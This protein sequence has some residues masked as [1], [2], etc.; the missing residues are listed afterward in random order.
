MLYE[1]G[2]APK[3]EQLRDANVTGLGEGDV[4]VRTNNE[5]KSNGKVAKRTD[6]EDAVGWTGKNY[7]KIIK[8]SGTNATV[9]FTR[10]A[11]NS[12]TVNGTPNADYATYQIIDR[13]T[14][15]LVIPA[16][17]YIVTGCPEG[18]S[19]ETYFMIVQCTRSGALYT[20]GN[21]AGDGLEITVLDGDVMQLTLAIMAGTTASNMVFY[22][23][24]RRAD[25][26]DSTYEPYHDS[27]DVCK[28]DEDEVSAIC[29]VYGSKNLLKFEPLL[30]NGTITG[31]VQANGTLRYNGTTSGIAWFGISQPTGNPVG[32]TY[33]TLLRKGTYK[34][35]VKSSQALS[36]NVQV[37]LFSPAATTIKN[38]SSGTNNK[39]EFTLSAD[40]Y[41]YVGVRFAANTSPS[42]FDIQ[43]WIIDARIKDTS[44]A[45]YAPINR[46]CMSYAVNTK[47]GVHNILPYPYVQTT[48]TVNKMTYTDMG[49]GTVKANSDGALTSPADFHCYY[50][51]ESTLPKGRYI[52]SDGGGSTEDMKLIANKHNGATYLSLLVDCNPAN[53]APIMDVTYEGYSDIRVLIYAKSGTSASNV[54]FKPMI[55]LAEDTDRT[56]ESYTMTNRELTEKTSKLQQDIPIVP[57]I[58]PALTSTTNNANNLPCGFTR[59]NDS[60]ANMPTQ[61]N[62]WYDVMTVR[63]SNDS[64][65]VNWGY[66]FQLAVQTTSDSNFGDTYIRALNGGGTPSWSAWKKLN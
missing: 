3:V 16:G 5:W 13:N 63:Q 27:V 7:A 1:S 41:V 50:F 4:L 48:K 49:D 18:G 33:T 6:I 35:F 36:S 23:M 21:D 24:I 44:Y 14:D 10:N 43:A 15:N 52:L 42:N 31:S 32:D 34:F 64:G 61:N 60:N 22:P 11:D 17:K 38:F 37:A 56:F 58:T 57:F 51:N 2:I 59:L 46:D 65:T 30:L 12:F 53:H 9:T 20:F 54:M 39:Y 26:S 19:A 47:L 66:G 62:V 40:T 29:N 25:I 8:P 45:D 55:T 28:A